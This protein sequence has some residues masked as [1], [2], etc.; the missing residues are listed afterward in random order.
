MHINFETMTL[1]SSGCTHSRDFHKRNQFAALKIL[2]HTRSLALKVLE[3]LEGRLICE[4]LINFTSMP[5]VGQNLTALI[6]ESRLHQLI[7]TFKRLLLMSIFRFS[8]VKAV[9]PQVKAER[10]NYCV[11][12]NY[13]TT[14]LLVSGAGVP[15]TCSES[16]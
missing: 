10:K 7:S 15:V 2:I 16:I 3:K 11:Q 5:W 12:L 13:T 6:V 14:E 8:L 4:C 9:V 1:K